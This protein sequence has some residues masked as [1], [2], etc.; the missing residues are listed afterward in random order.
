MDDKEQSRVKEV[1]T[2]NLIT[3]AVITKVTDA[4]VEK[5]GKEIETR[6]RRGVTQAAGLWRQTDGTG[7]EFE[8]FCTKHF[9]ALENERETVFKKIS[10]NYEALYGHFD[11][12]RLQ[13][14]RAMDLPE[15]DVHP[16]D[17]LF[18]G[19]DPGAHVDDDFYGNKIAFIS[20]L[21][22][23]FYSLEEKK[24]LG[25]DWSGK[26]WAYARLGDEYVARVPARFL[27]EYSKVNSD[28]GAYISEYNIF[29]GQVVNDKN[30][31]L[32][33][34]DMVL[35]SHWNLR[36]ELKANY[37]ADRGLEK[38]KTVYQVMKRIIFQDIPR[39]VI[40][41]GR[42]DWNPFQNKVYKDG[43]EVEFETETDSRYGHLL[44]NFKALKAIDAYYPP[45]M[46]TYIKR[47]FDRE[48]E[49]SQPEVEALF[50]KF[51][52]SPQVKKVAQLISSRLN[53]DLEPFDIWYD[54][55]KARSGIS[56]EKLNGM[57]RKKYP[58]AKAM[59]KD[60][61]GIL[62]KLGFSKEKAV[63][64]ASK[65]QVDPA[66]GSGHA[67]GARMKAATS[68]LRTRVPRDGMNYK[69][70]N[71]AIHEL[72]HNVEQTIS[73]HDV[74][75]YMMEGVPNTAFTE[76]LAFMFQERD[77][78][79]LGIKESNPDKKYLLAL[80]T[81][82]SVYEIMG[83]SLVDMKAW[84]WM[85]SHPEATPRQLKEA[86]IRIAVEVWNKY[87]ADAFG[88]KDQPILAIYS[89]MISYP[90]YL[91]AYSYGHLIHFQIERFLEGKDFA[92]EAQRMFSAGRLI[93]QLWMKRAVGGEIAVEPLLHAA[94][95]AL[96]QLK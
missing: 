94:E 74:D 28:A 6:A 15:G 45:A 13:F 2:A 43:V 95:D 84:K 49:I 44:E 78:E 16:V 21:N 37:G 92:A 47:K 4:L 5:Y 48:M 33:P 59:E 90:L 96:Q 1:K 7:A 58:T 73:L 86:V 41:N 93:P 89:H 81:F 23:P 22:F 52:S 9:I 36:D 62:L 56:E 34:K 14:R 57:T 17:Y 69:G 30:E 31:K 61:P 68:L 75:Y 24:K 25:P 64:L 55:F 60:L 70:Y 66:R 19:Y 29:M 38:Q 82:W 71:I 18:G 77:L 83:V 8:T 87:Y 46:D 63:F 67:W 42:L 32:F 27:Q 3:E 51:V 20:V 79:L 85:Y 72:G 11:R 39:E 53:R 76:A 26:E 88:V 40:N 91:S 12:I 54:G 80:D 65:I 35:L 50:I 10:E